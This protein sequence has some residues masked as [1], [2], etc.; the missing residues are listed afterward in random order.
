MDRN[1][2]KEA[3]ENNNIQ[4]QRHAVEKMMERNIS[5]EQVKKVLCSGE[6]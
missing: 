1:I 5:R 6:L 4:W 2:L 3:T